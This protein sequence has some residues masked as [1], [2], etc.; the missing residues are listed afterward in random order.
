MGKIIIRSSSHSVEDQSLVIKGVT[1]KSDTAKL[2]HNLC[3]RN[4]LMIAMKEAGPATTRVHFQF[5]SIL[6]KKKG[7]AFSLDAD[8]ATEVQ[9]GVRS[10]P[11]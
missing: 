8:P 1:W 3:V 9:V 6:V 11:Q 10:K 4:K 2:D 7:P 5:V